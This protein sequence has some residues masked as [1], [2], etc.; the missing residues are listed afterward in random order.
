MHVLA[1]MVFSHSGTLDFRQRGPLNEGLSGSASHSG[2][3]ELSCLDFPPPLQTTT[4]ADLIQK[5]VK[6]FFPDK[7]VVAPAE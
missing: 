5:G 1:C 4:I 2:G 7:F 6:E 3:G